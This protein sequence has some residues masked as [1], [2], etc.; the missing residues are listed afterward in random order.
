MAP[1]VEVC[2]FR[3]GAWSYLLVPEALEGD[4]LISEEDRRILQTAGHSLHVAPQP[5]SILLADI[6]ADQVTRVPHEIKHPTEVTTRR[7]STGGNPPRSTPPQGPLHRQRFYQPD[8]PESVNWTNAGLSPVL[9]YKLMAALPGCALVLAA[10][11]VEH[12]VQKQA[13]RVNTMHTG[14]PR[15]PKKQRME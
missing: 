10:P 7:M 1:W 14:G 2:R 9:A 4:V 12:P 3:A 5:P 11:Q 6:P 13:K 15:C 8:P